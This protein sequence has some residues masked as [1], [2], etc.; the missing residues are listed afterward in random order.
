MDGF[1]RLKIPVEEFTSPSPVLVEE[2]QSAFDALNLMA[3][4]EYRH[5]P[6]MSSGRLSGIISDRDILRCGSISADSEQVKV[7]DLMTKEVY[8]VS[9][10]E[11][12]DKVVFTM[13]DKKIGSAIVEDTDDD[14]F[15]IFT[16][17]DALNALV[18]IMRG[19]IPLD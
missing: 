11:N 4:H 15:G 2:H 18:E 3:K 13:S 19:D 9:R 12:L 17:T 6:V 1:S 10:K 5:I 7:K 8:R 16:S 14:F